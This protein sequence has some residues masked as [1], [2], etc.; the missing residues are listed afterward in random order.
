MFLQLYWIYDMSKNKKHFGLLALA[1][2]LFIVSFDASAQQ[3]KLP[4][5]RIMQSNGTIFKA[6]QLPFEKPILIIYFS[7]DCDHCQAFMKDFFKSAADFKKASVVMV[8]Y[9]P[10]ADVTKFVADFGVNK[11]SN[12]YVGTEGSSFFLKNYYKLLDMPFAAL[13]DKNGNIM[14]SY[15]SNISLNEL[16]LKIK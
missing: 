16:A 8:T 11:Y 2:F 9:R 7:P 10:I 1:V 4:P 3:G 6:E 5:F 15:R 12:I 13:Y 14:T